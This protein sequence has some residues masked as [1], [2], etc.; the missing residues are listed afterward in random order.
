[1]ASLSESLLAG[2]QQ[3]IAGIQPETISRGVESGVGLAQQVEKIQQGRQKLEQDKQKILV[4]KLD[5]VGRSIETGQSLKEPGA[6]ASFFKN[7]FPK[8]VKALGLDKIITEDHMNALQGS[9]EFRNK[10]LGIRSQVQKGQITAE[11]AVAQIADFEA[12][13]SSNA[14]EI[15][16]ITKDCS[17]R[18]ETKSLLPFSSWSSL[19]SENF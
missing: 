18:Q 2:A 11:Q 15:L 6:Q 17:K 1:M 3:S 10:F 8:Q 12:F 14:D 16:E 5:R 19:F 4:Q 9:S 13:T 7:F